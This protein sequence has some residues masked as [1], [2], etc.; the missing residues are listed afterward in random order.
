[1]AQAPAQMSPSNTNEDDSSAPGTPDPMSLY[2]I[3]RKYNR[4]ELHVNPLKWTRRHMELLNCS[5]GHLLKEPWTVA[6]LSVTEENYS[7]E[8]TGTAHLVEFFH[9]YFKAEVRMQGLR[10]LLTGDGCPLVA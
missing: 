1:M 10:L 2:G 3:V 8:R 7:K 6:G 9:Y 5:F 4:E